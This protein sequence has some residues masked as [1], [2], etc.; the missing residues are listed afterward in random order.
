MADCGVV[1][2]QTAEPTDLMRH[3][4]TTSASTLNFQDPLQCARTA[5]VDV[6]EG[7]T[8]GQEACNIIGKSLDPEGP[9]NATGDVIYKS[10]TS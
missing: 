9:D 2:R 8:T 3:T 4:L 7:T 6:A 5:D 1:M 10:L